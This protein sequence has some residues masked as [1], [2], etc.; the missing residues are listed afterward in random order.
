MSGR[1]KILF[2]TEGWGNGGIESFI[3]NAINALGSEDFDFS[4]FCTHDA[5]SV[6][7]DNLRQLKVPRFVVFKGRKPGL[8]RR[9]LES[10]REWGRLLASDRYDVVH[11]N[12]MNGMGFVYA[13]IAKRN[14][15]PVRLVHSH[16][17][18]FG[19]GLRLVKD[20]AHFM[21]RQL[22]GSCANRCLAC[23]TEAGE[24][25]FGERPFEVVKNAINIDR[26]RFSLLV[27]ERMRRELGV[28]DNEILVGNIGR[29]S[30][31]K[32]PVFQLEVFAE[33][34]R[35]NPCAKYLMVGSGELESEVEEAIRRLD[36]GGLVLRKA[37]TSQPEKYLW[38]LDAFLMPSAFE[39][40]AMVCVEA[41]C[42]G[43]PLLVSEDVS[44]EVELTDLVSRCSLSDSP[45]TWSQALADCLTRYPVDRS[46]YAKI[47]SDSGYSLPCF[48]D[49]LKIV[50]R[51]A[52]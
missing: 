24:Y 8:G 50:Y 10:T 3:T 51:L 26:F 1:K 29:L 6:F 18:H 12:T 49:T 32:N 9:F 52:R 39:G 14:N 25:L 31:A 15:V 20:M 5:P 11:I 17:T 38:A 44:Q 13:A 28:M 46:G 2:Y 33:F 41:Q 4:V 37:S 21:G 35:N 48:A 22:W 19:Q 40:L 7:D 42:A 16:N 23:S 47:I 34:Q 43:L 30:E 36:I 45:T 27:R